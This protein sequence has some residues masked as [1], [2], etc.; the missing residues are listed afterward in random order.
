MQADRGTS[1]EAGYRG[2]QHLF[3]RQSDR[4]RT[5]PPASR[6][7]LWTL[8]GLPSHHVLL[9]YDSRISALFGR[10]ARIA[11][12]IRACKDAHSSKSKGRTLIVCLDGTGNKLDNDNSNII[13]LVSCLKKDDPSQVT[14]YQA[15]IGTYNG[16][17]LAT[18]IS[19]AFDMA[20]GSGLGTHVRDAYRFLMQNYCEG[21]KI[22]LFGFSRGAYT[23]RCL[24][25]ML[26]KVSLLPAH[27]YAQIPFAHQCYKD[28]SSEGWKMSEEFKRTFS[29]DASAFSSGSG[30]AW[31]ALG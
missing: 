30:T 9:D 18:G 21:D 15:G 27:N 6:S 12:T 5:S 8:P 26:H 20:I 7:G 13:H 24:A 4:R 2:M 14:Y 25:G 28:D 29:M 31:L 11:E 1:V 17:G 19:A 3:E 16:S 10:D 23:A 22:C